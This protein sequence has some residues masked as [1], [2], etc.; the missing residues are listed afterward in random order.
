M[1]K[2]LCTCSPVFSIS[3]RRTCLRSY[4]GFRTQPGRICI[5]VGGGAQWSETSTTSYKKKAMATDLRLSG[6]HFSEGFSCRWQTL[7]I[8]FVTDSQNTLQGVQKFNSGCL[9]RHQRV[10]SSIGKR[11]GRTS[12]YNIY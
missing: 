12:T 7:Y 6:D 2:I 10:T 5:K 3:C 4:D 9:H 11:S 8:A 1:P